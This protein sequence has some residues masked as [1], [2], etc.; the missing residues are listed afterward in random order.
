MIVSA[1]AVA[2]ATDDVPKPD[3]MVYGCISHPCNGKEFVC[4][5]VPTSCHNCGGPNIQWLRWE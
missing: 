2:E 3:R 1:L 5:I 4:E